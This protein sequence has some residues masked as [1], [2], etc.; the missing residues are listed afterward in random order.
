[1]PWVNE[2]RFLFQHLVSINVD[3]MEVCIIQSNNGDINKVKL[4]LNLIKLI[5]VS[6][7]HSF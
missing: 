1:M 3:S 2:S 7:H 6:S 4:N 5:I